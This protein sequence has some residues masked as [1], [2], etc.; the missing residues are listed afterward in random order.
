MVKRLRDYD[1]SYFE[2]RQSG[3]SSVE[4]KFGQMYLALETVEKLSSVFEEG[5]KLVQ[6]MK[7]AFKTYVI[8]AF[9]K[10]FLLKLLKFLGIQG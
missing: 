4:T 6:M 9:M 3:N 1:E 10:I 7:L 2:P 8:S 5:S